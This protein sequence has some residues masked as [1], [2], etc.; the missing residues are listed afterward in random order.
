MELLYVWINQSKNKFYEQKGINLSPE[1]NF[2]VE[3]EGE[4]WVLSED[5]TWERK[6][7][8]FK[9]DVIENV[10]AVIG[11]NG[12]GK[13]TLLE[14]LSRLSC[15]PPQ[16]ILKED[17]EDFQK[18]KNEK[19]L[20]IYILKEQE[21]IFIYHSFER[22][23]LNNTKY[24]EKA[25]YGD[26]YATK[27]HL[28][29][30]GLNDILKLYI[31]NSTFGSIQRNDVNREAKLEGVSLS[32]AGISTIAKMYFN[33]LLGLDEIFYE[34]SLLYTWKN[35]LKQNLDLQHFQGICDL[36]YFHKL[37][38]NG[39]MDT[40]EIHISSSISLSCKYAASLLMRNIPQNIS[41]KE[42]SFFDELCQRIDKLRATIREETNYVIVNMTTNLVLEMCIDL[43]ISPKD[44]TSVAECLDWIKQN[45]DASSKKE[46]YLEAVNEIENLNSILRKAL[47]KENLLPKYDLAYDHSLVFDRDKDEQS[48]ND[49]LNFIEE[50]FNARNSLIL[51]YIIIENIGMSSGERAFQNFFSWI[52][53]MPVFNSID[54]SVPKKMR[55]TILILIDEIDLYLHPDWQRKFLSIMLEEIHLQFSEYKVQII[56]ATHS[57]LCLSDI[58]RENTVYLLGD[59]QVGDRRKHVQTFGKDVYSL[60]NDAFYLD[61]HT[62]GQYAKTYIDGIIEEMFE[63]KPSKY[64]KLSFDEIEKIKM[65][66]NVIGNDVL[67][68]K[69]LSMVQN[70]Y[71]SKQ[72]E[73]EILYNQK[74]LIERRIAELED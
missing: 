28:N 48:Y 67:K 21:N 59:G 9:D 61:G 11:R 65:K 62:M 46:Y 33:K 66:I 29:E 74:Q 69:L 50:R 10:T 14:H 7:S 42:H 56:F 51:R 37:I 4:T 58:P 45:R 64:K 27:L 68:T 20:Y 17:Y 16:K 52:N 60:L 35:I 41:E 15:I 2:K 63:E 3:K 39:K 18:N 31:S 38:K 24:T 54:P 55:N 32:P 8:I 57:P 12:S 1:Y 49:F 44:I 53:L 71:P 30:I 70:C 73:L 47:G 25:M 72:K 23:F 19:Y 43:E 36:L 22:N 34:K 6:I 13:T 40:Y 5:E 26:N